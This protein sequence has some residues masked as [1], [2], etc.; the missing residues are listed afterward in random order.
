MLLMFFAIHCL[1]ITSYSNTLTLPALFLCDVSRI[2]LCVCVCVCVCVRSDSLTSVSLSK[3][4]SQGG[5]L[6]GNRK[7][8]LL[9]QQQRKRI[10][11]LRCQKKTEKVI[12]DLLLVFTPIFSM[13]AC[14]EGE[15]PK[16]GITSKNKPKDTEI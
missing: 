4:R 8:G 11:R 15:G 13:R 12:K 7:E 9:W 1:L 6:R 10:E 2:S 16:L 5:K 3:I 14:R